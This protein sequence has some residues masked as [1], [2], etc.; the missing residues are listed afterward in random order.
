[1]KN[2]K[3]IPISAAKKIAEE[4]GYDQVLIYARKVDDESNDIEGGEH[5]TSYGVDKVH[6]NVAAR[7]ARYLQKNVFKWPAK[8]W[9]IV[10]RL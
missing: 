2:H 6:C 1:M 8:D 5:L 7:M 4:Y 9:V 3:P 10:P